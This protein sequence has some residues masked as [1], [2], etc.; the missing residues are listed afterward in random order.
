MQ[1]IT[2]LMSL[3]RLAYP[4]FKADLAD[5]IVSVGLKRSPGVPYQA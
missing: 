4:L 5:E 3:L 2:M 1:V